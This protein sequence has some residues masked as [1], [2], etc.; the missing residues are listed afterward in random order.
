MTKPLL[1]LSEVTRRYR[2]RKGLFGAR[3]ELTAVNKLSLNLAEGETLG[4]VG[5]SGCGKS[6]AVKL[7]LGL[8]KPDEGEVRIAGRSIDS[9]DRRSLSRMVQPVFQDP[10]YSLNPTRNVSDAVLQPLKVHRVA[11]DLKAQ[12]RRMLDLVG[13]PTRLAEAYPA[14]LSGGQRQRV[15]I[16]RALVLKP[17]IL[18]CDEP[19]SA[20]D[21]SVQAQVI[22]LLLELR[23]ELTLTMIFVSHNLAVVEHISDRVSVM[24]LGQLVEEAETDQLFRRPAHPYTQML[25]SST[26]APT[27]G[28]GLPSFTRHA[29]ADATVQAKGCAFA[30]RCE[31]AQAQCLAKAPELERQDGRFIRCFYPKTAETRSLDK[32][33]S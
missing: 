33:V 27:P 32:A 9:I 21:V 6:T 14:Q 11:G 30:P 18:I 25:L 19:T 24:Y 1:S 15:A 31:G 22:N 13:F 2:I 5:E 23:R 17:K 20:L 4:L 28:A 10:Y 7:M 12:V 16:A 3:R 26:L 29:A 8:E